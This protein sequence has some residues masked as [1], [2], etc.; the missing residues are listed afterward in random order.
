MIDLE[1]IKDEWR[2]L[3]I[4]NE[5]L[6]Q[7]NLELTRCLATQRVTNNQQKLARS[8]RVGYFGFSFPLFA[9]FLYRAIDASIAL[10]IA[11]GLFGI[12]VGCWDLWFRKFVKQINYLAVSTVEALTHASK[13][14][15]YQNRAT[16]VCFI[17]AAILLTDIFYEMS[18]FG[19]YSIV[20]GGVIG[21]IVGGIIG[22]KKCIKNHIRARRMLS[23]LKSIEK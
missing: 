6:R 17:A 4:E 10:C 14:V 12:V 20:T 21:A 3:I 19:D 11:Y 15:L 13:I 16:I 18:L 9:F 23:E 2:S 8:Y 22:T 1:Q 5:A 7:K